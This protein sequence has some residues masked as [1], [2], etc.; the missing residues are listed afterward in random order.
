M[1]NNV[2]SISIHTANTHNIDLEQTTACIGR[3]WW[4]NPSHSRWRDGSST[5]QF[6]TEIIQLNLRLAETDV[7]GQ[8]ARRRL[9]A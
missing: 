9:M 2:L 3:R 7:I 1:Q 4:R 6:I 8:E 5:E